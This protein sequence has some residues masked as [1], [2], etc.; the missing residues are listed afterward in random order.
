ML[1]VMGTCYVGYEFVFVIINYKEYSLHSPVTLD[2][3]NIE[4][5]KE[6][7]KICSK[8]RTAQVLK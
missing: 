6:D 4:N 3:C 7:L 1:A 2:L 5:S 8:K